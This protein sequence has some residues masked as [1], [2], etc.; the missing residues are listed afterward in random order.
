MNAG[1]NVPNGPSFVGT[2]GANAF[3]RRLVFRRDQSHSP[4]RVPFNDLRGFKVEEPS[5]GLP[6]TEATFGRFAS[7]GAFA[8]LFIGVVRVTWNSQIFCGDKRNAN[9]RD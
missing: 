1:S 2:I 8:I 3:Q 9:R 4:L 6:P 5:G 7:G